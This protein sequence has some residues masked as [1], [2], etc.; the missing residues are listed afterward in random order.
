MPTSFLRITLDPPMFIPSAFPLVELCSLPGVGSIHLHIPPA[1]FA[2]YST[3]VWAALFERHPDSGTLQ[4]PDVSQLDVQKLQDFLDLLSSNHLDGKIMLPKL[5]TVRMVAAE[6]PRDD[7]IIAQLGVVLVSRWNGGC[8]IPNVEFQLAPE[9]SIDD[10]D[11][12]DNLSTLRERIPAHLADVT[13]ME[14][15]RIVNIDIDDD[16]DEYYY[17]PLVDVTLYRS[18]LPS[19]SSASASVLR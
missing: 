8:P 1:S 5:Q 17:A 7:L 13:A 14:E 19:V 16:M 6:L 3:E 10:R 4:M 15:P 2:D 18:V 11:E 12:L 9:R